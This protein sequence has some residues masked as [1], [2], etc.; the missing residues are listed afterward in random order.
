MSSL[1]RTSFGLYRTVSPIFR[2]MQG[3]RPHICPF[4]KLIGYVPQGASVLD[5]GC[6]S[7]LFLALLAS[8]QRIESG[9]GFDASAPAIKAALA[10]KEQLP[11]GSP[12]QFIQLDVGKDWPEG[13]FD[14]VS[15]ID[16][17]HHIPPKA[18]TEVLRQACAKVKPG[19]IFLY[20]DM[21]ERP[22]WRATWNRVHDLILARQWIHYVPLRKVVQ[23][24][25]AEGLD[26]EVSESIA[27][28]AYA[29]ELAV[30]RKPLYA[31]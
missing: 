15:L 12:V 17:L 20:K 13:Q 28:W 19:G 18:Q 24:A 7:G 1:S 30:F 3:L 27:T 10:M 2:M 6:G 5:I 9:I 4:D 31:G 26:V 21:A 8:E 25:S 14:V 23:A 22:I 16:V 11:A 29:H